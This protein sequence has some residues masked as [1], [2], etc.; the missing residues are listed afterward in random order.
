MATG[1]HLRCVVVTPE[2]ALLDDTVDSV[3]IPMYDGELGVYPDRAPLIGKLGFGELRVEKDGVLSRYFVDGG[4]VQIRDNVVTLLT[5]KAQPARELN[6]AAIDESL[7]AAQKVAAT[8][9][10]QD[11]LLKTQQKARAQRRILNKSVE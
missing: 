6:A 11:A 1:K 10:E 9:E 4:F 5:S 8:P 2:K 7:R 3:V